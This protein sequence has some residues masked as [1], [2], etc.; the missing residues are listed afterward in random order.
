MTTD[1]SEIL[2]KM[3]SIDPVN[4]S[5]N[6][7]F[8]DGSVS[9][10]SPYIS[11][12]VISTKFVFQ[13]LIKKGYEFSK[14]EKFI[15]ELCWRDYWQLIWVEKKILINKD[16]K[17][18][19]Q[20]V[21]NYLL[22]D[23]II[24]ASTGIKAIDDSI[25]DL[26]SDGYMH[27]HLRMYVS[28]LACN[29]AKSHWKN[30]AKWMYYYL[31]DADWGS[32][33]LSWQWV[34]GSNSNKKYYANQDNINKYCYTDQKNTFLDIDYSQFESL[35]IP[36]D[37]KETVDP[38][39]ETKLPDTKDLIIDGELPTLIYNFYNL[40]PLWRKEEECNRILLLEPEIFENYPISKKSI[41]FMI[42]LSKNINKIQIHVG[43]FTHLIK[44]YN[45]KSII[46]KEHPLNAHYKGVEDN[47]DWMF[48][49]KDNLNSF[50]SYWN[51]SKK[52]YKKSL[53]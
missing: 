28:S 7:N 1:Y 17:K 34:C 3:D 43:S 49:N 46:F 48:E 42:A 52:I 31:L 35:E 2:K 47:R 27:N 8:I 22:S 11:R 32:N 33:A 26:Y 9:K 38:N 50:F 12:G 24:K 40:D 4:Y 5:R 53:L 41:E 23:S 36:L 20:G 15:Q 21:D 39:L 16:L 6:R 30:P 44:D 13:Y 29:I 51:K 45:L 25:M 10:L 18:E 19:Q 14:I 37:L